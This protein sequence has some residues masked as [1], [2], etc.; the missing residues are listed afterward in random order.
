MGL[1][2]LVDLVEMA[3]RHLFLEPQSLMQVAVV[4]AIIIVVVALAAQAVAVMEEVVPQ[5]LLVLLT[6]VAEV[7]V[8]ITVEHGMPAMQAAL[9]S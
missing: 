4:A 5:V 9:A 6:L 2:L 7:E 8:A 3:L 1:A